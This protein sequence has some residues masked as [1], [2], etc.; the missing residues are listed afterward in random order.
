[1][2][3]KRS[4]RQYRPPDDPHWYKD[5]IIY[6]VHVRAFFDANEDGVGDFRGLTQK[7]DYLEFLGVNAIWLLPFYP[8]PLRDE[9]YDIADYY[10]VHES[11]GTLADFEEFLDEAHR[12]NIRVIT[13]LVVNH[14]SDQH[15]WFQ[16]ARRARPGS[17][18]RDFYAW[19]DSPDRYPDARI[20]FED[21]ESSNWAYDPVAK[22]Y[23]WHRFY[24]HQPDLNFDNPDVR[25]AVLDALDFW[26]AKGV[27]GLRL[28]AIPYLYEREGTD[29]ENLP[30]TH[31]FLKELRRHVDE[32]HKNRV[33]LAEANQWPEDAAA[34]FGS[35]DECHMNFHFPLMPRLFMAIQS[36]DRFPIVDILRQT[37][38][39][40]DNAQWALFLRNHDE[41][42][43]EMV[44]DE[45]RDYMYR[46]YAMQPQARLNLGIRRRLAP[47]LGNNR[48][49]MELMNALLL[50]LPGTPVIYYGDEIG[51]GD[52]IYLGD[53]N[54]VRTP[55]Q[56]S[57]DRN[58]GFSRA[59]PQSLYLPVIID[60]AYHHE[61]VNVDAHIENP[62]SLLWW[63][64]RAIALRKRYRAFG[65]GT[66]QI[67]EVD[68]RK[69][70]AFV[71]CHGEE[72][73]LVVANLSRFAQCARID[74]GAFVGCRVVELFGRTRFPTVGAE[75]YTLCLGRHSFY[76]FVLE[77]A[78][79][80]ARAV[81]AEPPLLSAPLAGLLRGDE[82]GRLA[83]VLQGY[84]VTRRW[85]AGKDKV[86][87][88]L[89]VRDAIP[90]PDKS[91]APAHL[92]LL[93]V[94]Y[95]EGEAETY[96]LP[97]GV[98]R[99]ELAAWLRQ[100]AGHAV[101][102]RVAGE[103]GEGLL[104]DAIY[105]PQFAATLVGLIDR[106]RQLKGERGSVAG[107]RSRSFRRIGGGE[108]VREVRVVSGEQSN[109]SV[110]LDDRMLLKVYR[111]LQAGLHPDVE[112]G[113][114]LS[115]RQHFANTP[116]PGGTLDYRGAQ[117]EPT[118]LASLQH[119][120][121]N[122]GNAWSRALDEAERFLERCAS[123]Y[124]G[125]DAPPSPND[126]PMEAAP[127]ELPAVAHETVGPFLAD[128]GLL[129]TRTAEMHRGLAA[130]TDDPAFQPERFTKLARR[131][132]FQAVRTQVTDVLRGLRQAVGTL[133]EETRAMARE[134]LAMEEELLRSLRDVLGVEL[135]SLRIRVH[136]DYHLGQVLYTGGDF[137]IIDFEGE[138][139]RSLGE[140]RLKRS[141]LKDVAG[142]LRSFEYAAAT[143]LHNVVSRVGSV[144]LERARLAT[145]AR[146]WSSWVASRFLGAY[147]AG[148]QDAG[149]LRRA[150]RA[151]VAMLLGLH[152]TEKVFYEL[153]Y[154]LANRPSWAWI[155][156]EGILGRRGALPVSS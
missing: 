4:R 23:Y 33:L 73:V 110:V 120:V 100:H 42:T 55:M 121:R 34:Y 116:A 101:I 30:E 96:L 144:S 64:K 48:R 15:E 105:A 83:E 129:G 24:S 122:Q 56:W 28:D 106:Q 150:S 2:T 18:A 132:L 27:D 112:V 47:L 59:N 9:G 84:L 91:L 81:A 149:F 109:T 77:T 51:M 134:V 111:R 154:E 52:N 151:E 22:A 86:V 16:R 107:T 148:V 98:A 8:S 6:E 67:L 99:A 46:A 17:R 63:M 88:E 26:M 124:A 90:L 156:L 130:E 89:R 65:R 92:C 45:E 25:R 155:P 126:G 1:M 103:D 68:N 40:P 75:P 11:Y 143:A 152:R 35:G 93:D 62:N 54:G 97:L 104:V 14:T 138:P 153:R 87:T 145:W 70:L 82:N 60:P 147:L 32:H 74:L 39:I 69:V 31:A 44:T 102:A 58:A 13:E 108:E 146:A 128:A 10:S 3:Q 53:R 50:S 141:P 85:Y 7:L 125:V 114:F 5:A 136:G 119:F 57:R 113:R 12:R 66:M 131:S 36:E 142:M 94:A 38:A 71:R 76:W 118:T 133:P 123:Q 80:E 115:E 61:A 41:L 49:A 140:R 139:A 29:C 21:F 72:T 135:R 137:M 95:T 79:A 20:I 117:R 37:P 78:R 127:S 43:L 19:S